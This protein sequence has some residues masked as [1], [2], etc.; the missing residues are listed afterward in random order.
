MKT[1]YNAKVANCNIWNRNNQITILASKTTFNFGFDLLN[2]SGAQCSL[3]DLTG[4]VCSTSRGY[5]IALS[6]ESGLTSK[7][8]SI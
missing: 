5:E 2:H 8:T 1:G 3:C 4:I 6:S 7:L